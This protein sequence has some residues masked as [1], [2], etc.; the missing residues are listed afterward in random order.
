MFAELEK[1]VVKPSLQF[2]GNLEGERLFRF[3]LLAHCIRTFDHDVP[4]S[5]LPALTSLAAVT[6]YFARPVGDRT[7]LERLA[8]D[9]ARPANLH[10]RLDYLHFNPEDEFYSPHGGRTARAG[11][12]LVP[13]SL[14]DRRRFPAIRAPRRRPL[15]LD[16][17]DRL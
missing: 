17:R 2:G 10:V 11:H 4:N 12:D 14:A 1:S 16:P 13:T 8:E 6:E 15:Y 5:A 3:T 7:R 9:P